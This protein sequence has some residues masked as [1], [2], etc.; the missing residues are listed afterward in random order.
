MEGHPE[1]T[2][3]KL[4]LLLM[5]VC[6]LL[7]CLAGCGEKKDEMVLGKYKGLTYANQ[8]FEVSDE[9]F[10]NLFAQILERY[11]TYE[12]L[13]DRKGTAV[14][15]GD[16]VNIDFSGVLD[17]ETEPFEGGTDKGYILEIGGGRFIAG[18]EDGLIG[19]KQGETVKLNLTFPE[20]YY[21]AYAGKKVT[22]TVTVNNIVEKKVREMN[23]ELIVDY[24]NGQFKTVDE[25]KKFASE[26]II[27]AKA[28]TYMSE[29]RSKLLDQIV[30]DTKFG[31]LDSEKLDGYY[32]DIKNYYANEALANNMSLEQYL[33]ATYNTTVDE[34]NAQVKG[35]AEQSMKE[36]MVLNA[37]IAAEKIVLTDEQYNTMV[38]EYMNKY[39]YTDQAKFEADYNKDKL[40]QSMLFDLAFKVIMDSAVAE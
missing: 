28:Q 36:E 39:D 37:I 30:A 15:K 10:E 2:M 21:A 20:Q 7:P 3:K 33:A 38:K 35:V 12:V 24:S 26:Y 31:K 6:L 32:N 8:T 25:Y 16:L 40:R 29:V 18:F 19:V 13:E 14:K 11:T 34:F 4:L 17:G 5:T 9:D 22:F 1:E 23:D 27:Q